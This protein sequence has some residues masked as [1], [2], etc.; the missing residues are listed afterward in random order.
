[1]TEKDLIKLGFEKVDSFNFLNGK[2]EYYYY[3]K[4]ITSGLS[5]IT[6]ANDEIKD[7][8]WY[9]EFFNTEIPVRYYDYGKVKKLFKIIEDGIIKED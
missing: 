4:D 5:F 1:M 3:V 9:V 7:G 2:P 6:N 8:N